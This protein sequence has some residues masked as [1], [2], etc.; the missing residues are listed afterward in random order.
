MLSNYRREGIFLLLKITGQVYFLRFHRLW[1]A[2][3]VAMESDENGYSGFGDYKLQLDASV[4]CKLETAA[5][6]HVL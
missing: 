6:G 5:S 3:S 1:L 4:V 2:F